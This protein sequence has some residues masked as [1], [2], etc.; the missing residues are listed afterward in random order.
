[1]PPIGARKRAGPNRCGRCEAGQPGGTIEA[2]RAERLFAPFR[3]GRKPNKR[4]PGG[5]GSLNRWPLRPG[6][7]TRPQ[8]QP[9][10]RGGRQV[11]SNGRLVGPI[12][13]VPR[14][15]RPRTA[16]ARKHRTPVLEGR[17]DRKKTTTARLHRPRPNGPNPPVLQAGPTLEQSESRDHVLT[18]TFQRT[19][20]TPSCVAFR[21]QSG[22]QSP[23]AGVTVRPPA[24]A[25][26]Q[27]RCPKR[28]LLIYRKSPP[29]RGVDQFSTGGNNL[30]GFARA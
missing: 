22:K 9:L 4:N 21:R 7:T 20:L 29:E 19:S 5:R 14:S 6:L 12:S 26:R 2:K 25:G 8:R 18:P 11:L 13:F 28:P 15:R 1:V 30:V 24:A 17:I 3:D 10:A 23:V 16:R 27:A